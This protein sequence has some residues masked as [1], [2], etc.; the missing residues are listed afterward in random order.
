[1][2]EPIITKEQLVARLG[3]V[4]FERVFDDNNDGAADK[5]SEE[6][7]R[8]DASGMVRGGIGLVFDVDQ[9]TAGLSDE[10][11]RVTLDVAEA[12]A[13]KRRPTIMMGDWSELM[14]DARE[15]IKALR[16]GV[17]NLGIK[18]PPEPAANQ[19][20]RM[21]SGNPDAPGSF[22]KRF[23]DDWGSF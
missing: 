2:A 18:S 14:K 10:L 15:S 17:A 16:N 4:L 3:Q 23:S 13:T 7:L 19:G 11:T 22:P 6:Q 8:R 12:M 5:L 9:L 20:V 1:M 21:T